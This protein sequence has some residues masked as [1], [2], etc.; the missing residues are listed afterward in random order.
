MPH[1]HVVSR[2]ATQT[3]SIHLTVALHLSFCCENDVHESISQ[4]QVS[5]DGMP[6]H[7]VNRVQLIVYLSKRDINHTRSRDDPSENVKRPSMGHENQFPD[8]QNS[9]EVAPPMRP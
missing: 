4:R 3:A 5:I 8:D 1:H 6:M 2:D 9:S 7:V